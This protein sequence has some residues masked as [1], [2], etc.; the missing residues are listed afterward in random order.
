LRK[1]YLIGNFES[2]GRAGAGTA[3]A[4]FDIPYPFD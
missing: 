1:K 3:P 4:L 2:A